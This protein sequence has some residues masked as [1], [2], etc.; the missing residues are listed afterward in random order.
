M[1]QRSWIATLGDS[2]SALFGVKF[3]PKVGSGEGVV[4]VGK[5]ITFY[6]EASGI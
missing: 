6:R 4:S 2:N 1:E 5:G 3:L